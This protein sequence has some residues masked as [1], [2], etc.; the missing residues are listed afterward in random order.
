MVKSDQSNLIFYLG[1]YGNQKN[2]QSYITF[3]NKSFS[4]PENI[5]KLLQLPDKEFS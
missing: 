5:I 3:V 4:K 2:V 1:T